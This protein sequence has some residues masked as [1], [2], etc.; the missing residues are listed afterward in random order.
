[1]MENFSEKDST[2]GSENLKRNINGKHKKI[3]WLL[4][5]KM[6][7]KKLHFLYPLDL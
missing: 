1:M 5:K 6:Q 2:D 4:M 3:I 7:K